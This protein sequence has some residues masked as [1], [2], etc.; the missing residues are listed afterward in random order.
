MFKFREIILLFME[1]VYSNSLKFIPKAVRQE[2]AAQMNL[3][4]NI[5]RQKT[6]SD[7]K[8]FFAF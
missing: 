1:L 6:R 3:S 7:M 4:V 2:P 8:W 5:E